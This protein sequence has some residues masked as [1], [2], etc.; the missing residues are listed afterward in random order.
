MYTHSIGVARRSSVNFRR[1]DI[2]PE[3]N[4][5]KINKMPEFYIKIAGKKISPEFFFFWG[6]GTY[7]LPPSPIRLCTFLNTLVMTT[8]GVNVLPDF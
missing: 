4:V 2:L 8:V 3:K 1:H 7:P 6:G 5:W